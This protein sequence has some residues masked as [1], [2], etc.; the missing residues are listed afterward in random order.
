MKLYRLTLCMAVV[1]VAMGLY[2]ASYYAL[3]TPWSIVEG[4]VAGIPIGEHV[5]PHYA[6]GG[7]VAEVAF[8]PIHQLDRRL[9]PKV[10]EPKFM[11]FR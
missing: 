10:W 9:R 5:E 8:Q 4:S 1:A 2:G 3:V 6:V 7:R 11:G